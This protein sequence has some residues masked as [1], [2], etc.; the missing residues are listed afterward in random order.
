M[1]S[2]TIENNRARRGRCLKPIAKVIEQMV[3][4]GSNF[5]DTFSTAYERAEKLKFQTD[6]IHLLLYSSL[7]VTMLVGYEFLSSALRLKGFNAPNVFEVVG[8][9]PFASTVSGDGVVT[10]YHRGKDN[11]FSIIKPTTGSKVVIRHDGPLPTTKTPQAAQPRRGSHSQHMD[12]D[13]KT[14]T[15]K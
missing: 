9:L 3:E 12:Y 4:K 13:E 15:Y 11:E 8:M 5:K 1:I 10:T 2:L 7:G 14:G 6:T